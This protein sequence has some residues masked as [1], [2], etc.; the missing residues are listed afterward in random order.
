M[1]I[2]QNLRSSVSGKVPTLAQLADGVIAINHADGKLYV[3][4]DA[5]GGSVATSMISQSTPILSMG[6]LSL[7]SYPTDGVVIGGSVSVSVPNPSGFYS[8]SV[9]QSI[10][11]GANRTAAGLPDG[12]GA[13]IGVNGGFGA[14]GTDGLQAM[15]NYGGVDAVGQFIGAGPFLPP[16]WGPL[17]RPG[18]PTTPPTLSGPDGVTFVLP[19][20]QTIPPAFRRLNTV[21]AI[22]GLTSLLVGFLS[23]VSA[24]GT[25]GTVA[26]WGDMA[27]KA[28]AVDAT[29]YALAT[30]STGITVT[31][32]YVSNMFGQNTVAVLYPYGP[33]TMSG[34]ELDLINDYKAGATSTGFSVNS[35]GNYAVG[36]AFVCNGSSANGG[37]AFT[38]GFTSN[39]ASYR[40]FYAEMNHDGTAAHHAVVG[41]YVDGLYNLGI[42]LHNP[43]ATTPDGTGNV[44][45]VDMTGGVTAQG[46]IVSHGAVTAAGMQST[47]AITATTAAGYNF[48]GQSSASGTPVNTTLIDNN[49]NAHFSGAV[50]VDGLI[51]GVSLQGGALIDIT[52]VRH[53]GVIGNGIVDDTAALQAAVNACAG[54]CRLLIP[55]SLTVLVSGTI[56]LP[57]NTFIQIAGLI[58][59]KIPA[60]GIVG[61]VIHPNGNN[62]II[63]GCG[64]GMIDGGGQAIYNY[65]TTNGGSQAAANTAGGL[66]SGNSACIGTLGATNYTGLLVKDIT[67]QYPCNW[68]INIVRVTNVLVEN[69]LMR[70]ALNSSEFALCNN[71]TWRKCVLHDVTDYGLLP[72]YG[73]GN[74]N[75]AENCEVY[76]TYCGI[77]LFSDAAQ[78]GVS[79]NCSIVNN[80][81]HNNYGFGI[82]VGGTSS[83]SASN[84]VVSGNRAVLNGIQT[85]PSFIGPVSGA[86]TNIVASCVKDCTIVD[87]IAVGF[88]GT[89]YQNRGIGLAGNLENVRVAGNVTG[90]CNS[91]GAGIFIGPATAV[92]VVVENNIV[93]DDQTS[94]HTGTA[95]LNATAQAYA[96]QV[97]IRGNTLAG[98]F[99][100]DYAGMVG[101]STSTLTSS[102]NSTN[103]VST[104]QAL[105]ANGLVSNG[106]TP[107]SQQGAWLHWNRS[108]TDG[109]TWLVNQKGGGAGGITFGEATV[110]NVFTQTM[111]ISPTG[112][113]TATGSVAASNYTVGTAG[114]AIAYGSGGALYLDAADAC[115]RA[116]SVQLQ[117]FAGT[118]TYL[119]ANSTGV[120]VAGS[121]AATTI[122]ATG[123]V[124]ATTLTTSGA[125]VSNGGLTSTSISVGSGGQLYSNDATNGLVIQLAAPAL[126]TTAGNTLTM[127][128]V[129]DTE[130]NAG[131]TMIQDYRNAAGSSWSTA[132][133]RIQHITDATTQGWVEFNAASNE[134]GISFGSGGAQSTG[135]GFH[136]NNG[137][138]SAPGSMT[139]GTTL[140]VNGLTTLSS[141]SL[142][143][144]L[145]AVAGS[146][147]TFSATT[148]NAT[149]TV[150]VG[151]AA[152]LNGGATVAGSELVSG[153]T[154]SSSVYGQLRLTNGNTAAIFRQDGNNLYFATSATSAT[155]VYTLLPMHINLSNGYVS[156]A[157][158]AG[159]AGTLSVGGA[160]TAASVSTS[161]GASVVGGLTADTVTATSGSIGSFAASTINATG[162][163]TGNTLK[164]AGNAAI[165]S[166]I[167][168]GPQSGTA[169][170]AYIDFHSTGGTEDYDARILVSGSST[171]VG[172][173]T[174]TIYA[175]SLAISAVLLADAG[176]TVTGGELVSTNTPSGSTYGQ[177]RLVNGS[178]G[179]LFVNDG[180]NIVIEGAGATGAGTTN[181][182]QYNLS[183]GILTLV[184]GI[185]VGGSAV[186]V[187]T[188]SAH[189]ISATSLT[190]TGHL[191]GTGGTAPTV[192]AGTLVSGSSDTRGAITLP[193]GTTSVT[194]TFA[195]AYVTAPFYSVT[196]T[197][198][199]AVSATSSTTTLVITV[200]S[201]TS[202]ITV[203]YICMQ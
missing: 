126:G 26:A 174:M 35:A 110:G 119:S 202:G 85:I 112:N 49:G 166:S 29:K 155:G 98:T 2:I 94:N 75:S 135:Y 122:S 159:I 77:G 52:D 96:A 121:L 80:Y 22:S 99:G 67:C 83:A 186:F 141:A 193:S 143:G 1:P 11:L 160:L 108:G 57:S 123:S 178:V 73:T 68:A 95:I 28:V 104:S 128:Q 199:V 148:I 191:I 196:P 18:A 175:A 197:V 88:T 179:A 195:T 9:G 190:N 169:G 156:M 171:T 43:N 115:V 58:Q 120:T 149:G 133:R 100:A 138:A 50:Q 32:G 167:E 34:Y 84:I 177:L 15:L 145:T 79:T 36:T 59:Y 72:S 124:S 117:N 40:S 111:T 163:V 3:R 66:V 8:S 47:Q 114:N 158:N 125:I 74:N 116:A 60:N 19:A 89:N 151:S 152:A 150:T 42:V 103:I 137:S 78:S 105:L 64:T 164:I 172:G 41:L 10:V 82:Y 181:A 63:D 185:T 182:F 17:A 101:G 146:I 54:V 161:A 184:N 170:P 157:Y 144:S 200:A 127:L 183:T 113:V 92:G 48:V 5:P 81:V 69:V 142:S 201:N 189:G 70:Y 97:I 173:E 109:G 51:N 71:A 45:A 187:G 33:T 147:G 55:E 165:G 46:N 154:L 38:D 180:T 93:M 7:N 168:L 12:S 132:S 153:P 76:N 44:F 106:N 56:S 61:D 102:N 4:Y 87:N 25:S 130:S 136:V 24:D 37:P 194:V 62:I 21:V 20:G 139:V 53:Y 192:S 16:A 39:S 6:N 23:S 86:S 131:I 198:A 118:S 91:I 129:K 203:N 162:T 176:A 140:T 30:G 65:Y 13:A 31:V 90:N 107:V 14:G 188:F 27:S 134:S